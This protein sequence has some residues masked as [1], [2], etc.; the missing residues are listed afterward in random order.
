[1][2]AAFL[3]NKKQE[4]EFYSKLEELEKKYERKG[5]FLAVNTC[6][7]TISPKLE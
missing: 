7:R 3:V 6:R 5:E 4:Q 1:M 2:H